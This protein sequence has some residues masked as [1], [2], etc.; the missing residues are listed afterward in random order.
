MNI[1]WNERYHK[2]AYII[3]ICPKTRWKIDGAG[4]SAFTWLEV[5]EALLQT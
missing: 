4:Y 5:K 1:L 3:N 2:S